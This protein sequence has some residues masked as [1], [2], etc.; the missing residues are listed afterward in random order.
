MHQRL[1]DFV[2]HHLTFDSVPKSGNGLD[3]LEQGNG[4]A[5]HLILILHDKEG[6]I[7]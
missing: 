2:P 4:E 5:V 1:S 3:V 7:G 6:V